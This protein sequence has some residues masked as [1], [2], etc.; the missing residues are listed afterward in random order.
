M[1]P[2][3]PEPILLSDLLTISPAITTLMSANNRAA[4]PSSSTDNF[5]AIFHGAS[6]EY[7]RV[8]GKRLDTNPFF[9]QLDACRTPEAVSNRRR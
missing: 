4:G 3:C 1:A 6:D 8:T 9:A 2:I 5:T 7:Q